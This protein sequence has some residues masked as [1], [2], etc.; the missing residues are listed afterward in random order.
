MLVGQ[1]FNAIT[2]NQR[3]NVLSEQKAKNIIKYQAE[4]LETP[5]LYLFGCVFRDHVKETANFQKE[6]KQIYRREHPK[7]N[8]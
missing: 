2:Y 3:S 7:Q 4:L 1:A 5:S 8:K 6:Y